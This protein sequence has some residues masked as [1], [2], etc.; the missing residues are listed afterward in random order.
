MKN[1]KKQIRDLE[2]IENANLEP[3]RTFMAQ[4]LLLMRDYLR[5]SF[6]RGGKRLEDMSVEEIIEL[7]KT[8]K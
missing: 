5:E 4:T 1:H 8:M 6:K 3:D 2:K 7:I